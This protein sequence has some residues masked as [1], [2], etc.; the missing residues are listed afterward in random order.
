METHA[1][2]SLPETV[3]SL[4]AMEMP[5]SNTNLFHYLPSLRNLRRALQIAA[6]ETLD[7]FLYRS[8]PCFSDKSWKQKGGG[9]EHKE[10]SWEKKH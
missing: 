8:T 4:V 1:G 7:P 3:L 9:Q 2:A 10:Q 6:N 5:S